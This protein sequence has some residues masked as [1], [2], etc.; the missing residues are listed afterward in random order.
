MKRSN[1]LR[2]LSGW[3]LWAALALTVSVYWLE[4]ASRAGAQTTDDP[5]FTGVS[6]R[7]EPTNL[8]VSRRRFEAGARSAWHHH[9]HGQLLYVEEGRARTQK[10]GQPLR[11]MGPGDSDYT[12][13]SVEHWH[14]A[15]RDEPFVQVNV[16]FGSGITWL[17]K[18]TDEEYEG[19]AR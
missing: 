14:G 19:G 13:P 8:S 5:R 12:A 10:R 11:E 18:V 16:G 6:T 4:H 9:D 15:A 3:I 1:R 2:Q 17:E 7:M